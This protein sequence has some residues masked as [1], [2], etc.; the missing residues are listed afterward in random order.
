MIRNYVAVYDFE[1]GSRNANR[2]Q[3]L[4]LAAVMVDL[5][6]LEVVPDSLFQSLIKPLDDEEAVKA[7]VDPVQDDALEKNKLDLDE[8]KKAPSMKVV[9]DNYTQYL[10]NYNLKGIKGSVWD[11]PAAGGY[12]IVNFDNI[13]CKRYAKLD[14][15]GGWD[16]Y[17]PFYQFDVQ[18][19]VQSM[20]FHMRLTE[21]SDSI[22]MDRVRKFLG[23]SEEMAHNASKDVLDTA[24]V[25]IKFLRLYKALCRGEVHLPKGSKINFH[26]CFQQENRIIATTL[27]I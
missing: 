12:N 10:K 14:D 13:I 26:D 15:Y 6:K 23:I 4:Q 24:Y 8:C 20:F 16:C 5:E 3:P 17:H 2:C 25:L 22:A 9:W 18:I 11:A 21:D 1:T 19:L 27:G 7:G